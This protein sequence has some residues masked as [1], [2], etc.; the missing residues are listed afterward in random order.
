MDTALSQQKYAHASTKALVPLEERRH[1]GL[2][3]WDEIKI[4]QAEYCR[5]YCIIVYQ[6]VRINEVPLGNNHI[7]NSPIGLFVATQK[8]YNTVLHARQI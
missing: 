6:P 2:H 3:V 8:Q 5:L 4:R 7:T 1:N